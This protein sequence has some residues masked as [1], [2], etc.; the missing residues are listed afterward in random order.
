MNPVSGI[1]QSSQRTVWSM[2]TDRR[3]FLKGIG[4]VG[5]AGLAAP[6]LA[7]TR[8]RAAGGG[9]ILGI[10]A[11]GPWE[12]PPTPTLGG[13]WPYKVPGALGCRSYRD[14]VLKTWQD[15]PTKFPGETIVAGTKVV[16]SIRPDPDKV[17]GD[18]PDFEADIKSM[19]ADGASRFSAPQ[20]TVWHEAGNLYTNPNGSDGSG[21]TWGDYNLTPQRVRSMHVKMQQWCDEVAAS[22][23]LPHVDYGCIIYGEISEMDQ[24][25]P[26]YPYSLDWYGI[27]VYYEDDPGWGRGDLV[28]Y[29]AVKNYMDNFLTLARSR[30]PVG[31]NYPKINV[32]ESNANAT[33]ADN[34]P[35]FFENLATWLHQ[36][37]GRRMLTFFPEGGGPHSVEWVPPKQTTIDALNW[38]QATYG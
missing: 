26:Y 14:K 24:W 6:L 10:N 30:A 34:R 37:G 19:I 33:N 31:V 7:S 20:L 23:G 17:L 21:G 9:L 4:L 36:N 38:I 27:D 12:S 28:D 8:A 2:R 22:T 29:T 3:T 5:A 1:D 32:C 35:Q 18:H 11:P 16:A 15:V 25:V 13:T